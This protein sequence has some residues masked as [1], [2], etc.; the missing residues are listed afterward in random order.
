MQARYYG[1]DASK[2]ELVVAQLDGTIGRVSNEAAAIA[3]WLEQ[4]PA[5][6]CIGVES[7]GCCHSLLAHLTHAAGHT[8][9]VLNA[10]DVH[11]YAK[12]VG[13]RAK[14]DSKDAGVIVRYLADHHAHLRPWRPGSALQQ[15]LQALLRYRARLSQH[16]AAL[17]QALPAAELDVD[18]RPVED[19]WDAG[20]RAIDAKVQAL[21]DSDTHL[22]A[23]CARLRTIIG[24]GP[25]AAALLTWLL[26]RLDFANADALV[27]YCG[28]DPRASD[29]GTRRGRRRLTK[30]GPPLL[31]RQVYL[32]GLAAS[33]SRALKP[34]YQALRAKGFATTEA[35]IILGRKLLRAAFVIWKGTE[36]FDAARLYAVKGLDAKA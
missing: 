11:F 14:T 23:G 10:H 25:Q 16:R 30:K 21:I 8:V 33:N 6:A 26:S 7:T 1:V 17:R 20:L 35:I 18:L 15:Q 3:Q 22:R 34:L 9:C 2:A 13:S 31:R 27:A 5:G 12:A 19:G 29:S 4:L 36:P 28:L 32:M 24:V